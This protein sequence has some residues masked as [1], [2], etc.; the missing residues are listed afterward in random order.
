MRTKIFTLTLFFAIALLPL[1]ASAQRPPLTSAGQN[2]LNDTFL[3][4]GVTTRPAQIQALLAAGAEIDCADEEGATV[5]M[6][7]AQYEGYDLAESVKTLIAQHANVN[8]RDKSGRTALF[9]AF[10]GNGQY[11]PSLE[12]VTA[13]LDAGADIN[14]VSRYGETPLKMA[15]AL[16]RNG[17]L[18]VQRF[19]DGGGAREGTK[20]RYFIADILVKT[21][22]TEKTDLVALLKRR[23]AKVGLA[24]AAFSRDQ[25]AI[26]QLLKNGA[27][28]HNVAVTSALE[29]AIRIGDLDVLKLL[30]AADANPNARDRK[31]MSLL[32]QAVGEE[33]FAPVQALVD[34]GADVNA[35]DHT[36]LSVLELVHGYEAQPILKL[37]LAR[38]VKVNARGRYGPML[39]DLAGMRWFR[40]I[41]R[42][43]D[44]FR[45]AHTEPAHKKKEISSFLVGNNSYAQEIA[46]YQF[47]ESEEQEAQLIKILLE[48]GANVNAHSARGHTAL[49]SAA[50]NEYDLN[51]K[52]LLAFGA[53]VNFRDKQGRT[54]LT[55][56][57]LHGPASKSVQDLLKAGAQVGPTE[58]LELEDFPRARTAI[59]EGGPITVRDYFGATPLMLAAEK[60]QADI[61]QTLL[62][63]GADPNAQDGRGNTALMFAVQG[64]PTSMGPGRTEWS[65]RRDME[66]RT[67]IVAILL[68]HHADPN[69]NPYFY[70]GRRYRNPETNDTE[71]TALAYAQEVKNLAAVDLLIQHGAR[72]HAPTPPVK[73]AR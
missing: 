4:E 14:A 67:K 65:G 21:Y 62:E 11:H 60:G 51:V 46:N 34:A 26:Q 66:A 13:L 72:P 45:P 17:A 49:M 31:G 73:S 43:G 9:Y 47:G 56:A 15:L 63:R 5:L 71:L 35:R 24:E 36:G 50:V 42:G 39:V 20:G 41:P 1:N 6:K 29:T 38:G 40:S 52:T 57:L 32:M 58:A 61:V 8:A 37:L 25:E 30:L 70:H 54:A 69:L 64:E 7:S 23:G 16:Q 53:D 27:D 68:D 3:R 33:R 55:L 28:I 12:L 48:G 10:M 19:L 18:T 44:S 2:K 22:T 59:V